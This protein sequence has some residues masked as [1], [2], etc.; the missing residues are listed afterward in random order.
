MAPREDDGPRR[1]RVLLLLTRELGGRGT[2]RLTV[3][4]SHVRALEALG[5]EVV[6]AVVAPAPPAEDEWTR[7][8]TTV[9]VPSPGLRSVAST[10]LREALL[11]SLSLNESLFVDRRVRRDVAGLLERTAPDVVV[12]DSVRLSTAVP[13]D[14]PAPVVVD[15]DDLLSARY[16]RMRAHRGRSGGVLGFAGQRVPAPLRP[17]AA[18]LAR[19]VLGWE[20]RRL[21]VREVQVARSRSAVSLVS[22]EEASLLSRSAGRPVHWL[23]PSVD[24]PGSPVEHAPGLVFVGGLDYRP[25][26]EALRHWRDQVAPHLPA[27]DER[28]LLHVVGHC[29]PALRGELDAPGLRAEGFLPDLRTALARQLMVAPLLDPG[30]VKLKV[31]D[32]MAHGLAVVGTPSAFEGLAAPPELRQE[33]P[34][35]RAMAELVVELVRDTARREA[36]QDAARAFASRSFGPQA[37]QRRWAELLEGL[38]GG[39]APGAADGR[40]SGVSAP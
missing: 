10:A 22:A 9:H 16:Q 23:P 12:V 6:V 7:R 14:C 35:G 40:P 34:G 39:P 30:G 2:G 1:R 19:T 11:G 21:A 3:L 33:A 24:V 20:A 25:N 4:R 28:Y 8:C 17:L 37:A 27:G 29:P 18:A 31:L 26:L 38:L 32:G 5:H 13:A 15:L 36:L